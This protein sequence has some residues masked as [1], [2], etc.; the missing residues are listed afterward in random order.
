MANRAA[1][2]ACS[3][4]GL[5]M[6]TSRV[7]TSPSAAS[8]RRRRRLGRRRT[9]VSD[10]SRLRQQVRAGPP[11]PRPR[12]PPPSR[13][14][15]GSAHRGLYD[16]GDQT[17]DERCTRQQDLAAQLVGELEGH[18]GGED[19]TPEVGDD[20][21]AGP[22]AGLRRRAGWR[23][24]PRPRRCRGRRRSR[25]RPRWAAGCR[26]PSAWPARRRP[27]RVAPSGRPR[28]CR[29]RRPQPS[30][31]AAASASSSRVVEAEPGS[32][33]PALRSPR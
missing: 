8:R 18:L 23:P 4:C 3:P 2:R 20:Q 15:E 33:C 5:T 10:G 19:R 22:A 1:G 17:L 27:R 16:G 31:R 6:S 32:M 14:R 26:P 28:R 21:D 7:V 11:S 24:R 29:P 30:W 25:P 9:R 13:R 12:R